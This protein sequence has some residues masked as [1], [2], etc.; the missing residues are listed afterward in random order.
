[1]RTERKVRVERR[2]DTD[3]NALLYL[4]IKDERDDIL[5]NKYLSLRKIQK[6]V[7]DK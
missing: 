2:E 1:M 3:S 5:K 4:E 6:R 7:R